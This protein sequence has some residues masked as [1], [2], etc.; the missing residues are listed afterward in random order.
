MEPEQ[1]KRWTSE[2]D[3]V[4]SDML[5]V[6]NANV[7][8]PLKR[9]VVRWLLHLQFAMEVYG[10]GKGGESL[11]ERCQN[12]TTLRN[13]DVKCSCRWPLDETFAERTWKH[14]R[15]CLCPYIQNNNGELQE[16]KAQ[17]SRKETGRNRKKV[18]M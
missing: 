13:K 17:V 8:D 9:R 7:N 10:T 3:R 14:L 5:P 11:P 16:S 15:N 2:V 12:I 4:E 18:D 1:R 6:L